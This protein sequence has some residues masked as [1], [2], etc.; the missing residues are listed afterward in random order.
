MVHALRP[1]VRALARLHPVTFE[2]TENLPQGPAILVGNH[3][4]LGYESLLF[5][6]RI[7]TECGRLPVGL[8]DR[9]FFKIPGV[10]D[11]LV[12]LGGARGTIPNGL[13]ALSQGNLLVIYP[14]GARETLKHESDKY[15]LL[16]GKSFGFARLALKAGVPIIPFAGAGVDDTFRIVAHIPGSGR[17]LMGHAKYDL[18]LVWGRRG[19]LPEAVPFSFRFGK[20]VVPPTGANADDDGAVR[21]FHHDVWTRTQAL[22]SDLTRDWSIANLGDHPKL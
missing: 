21:A 6:E 17:M 19:L 4:T 3:G 15:R 10:R 9:F 2:G 7:F 16:W 20:P 12:R 18:P 1:L 13:R 8:A 5:F 22:L 14:G 11:V